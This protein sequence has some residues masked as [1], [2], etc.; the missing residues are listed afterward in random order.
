M[1]AADALMAA[2]AAGIRVAIDGDDLVLEAPAPP[3]PSVLGL[4]ARNKA[5]IVELLRPAESS[6]TSEDSQVLLD[7]CGSI[8][9]AVCEWAEALARLD[10]A[11]P[12]AD[13][14]A[15]RWRRF[16]DDCGVFLDSGW[17]GR[18][19]AL[20]WGPLE[21]F[22]CDH[23]K[24]FARVSRQGL[25]WLLNGRPLL[26]LT[27]GLAAIAGLAGGRLSYYRRPPEPGQVLVWEL[28]V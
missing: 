22:G 19:A 27:D 21:L 4:L 9:G 23:E 6:W 7:E 18:A 15:G 28:E 3:P 8:S 26:A 12:P 10:P 25:L 17:A 13:V 1:S 2:R 5:D 14:P 20:G 11:R 24:P 16:I